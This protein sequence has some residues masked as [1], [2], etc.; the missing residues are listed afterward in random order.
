MLPSNPYPN[1]L[2]LLPQ[3]PEPS[4]PTASAVVTPTQVSAGNYGTQDA[5]AATALAGTSTVVL[6][7]RPDSPGGRSVVGTATPSDLE[8]SDLV[9]SAIVASKGI[10]RQATESLKREHGLE[11]TSQEML[12]HL[13]GRLPELKEQIELAAVLDLFGLMP[14]MHKT[15]IENLSNLSGSDAVRGY[16]DLMKLIASTTSKNELNVNVHEEIWHRA[17]RDIQRLFAELEA[18]GQLSSLD[19]LIIDHDPDSDSGYRSDNA[20][21]YDAVLSRS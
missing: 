9:L 17:P 10:L 5:Q 2:T 1:G 21:S 13:K 7:D 19:H 3:R 15:L 11:L 12:G 18:T 20:D 4:T 6:D 8:L 16:M 14:Q